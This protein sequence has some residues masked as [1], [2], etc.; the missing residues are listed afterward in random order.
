M[1]RIKNLNPDLPK[2]GKKSY[3]NIDIFYIGYII[4]E[5]LGYTNIHSLSSLY[6]IVDKA[7]GYIE[8]SNGNKYL[9]LVSN[10]QNKEELTKYTK[11]WDKSKN[12]IKIINSKPGE[13]KKGYTKIRFSS[14]DG[15]PVFW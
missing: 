12:L 4:V 1:I 5:G 7:D 8:E 2:I 13:Y 9:T 6:F 11:K 14:D 15:L 3:K 10:D